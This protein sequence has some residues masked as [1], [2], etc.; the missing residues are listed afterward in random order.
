MSVQP[1]G[2]HAKE[3]ALHFLNAAHQPLTKNNVAKT[4][5]HAKSALDDGYTRDE[6]FLTMDNV[7]ET[8]KLTN[9]HSFGFIMSCIDEVLEKKRAAER[10]TVI[11][12]ESD[13]A[14]FE[15][16]K[17]VQ[18]D[19]STERNRQKAARAQLQSRLRKKFDF[20]MF[21]E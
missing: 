4:I 3:I 13:K 16:R 15:Q 14:I 6:I 5:K 17:E 21:E 1:N 12:A 19:E 18:K 8:R 11:L 7:F 9:I 2:T 20:D 10:A